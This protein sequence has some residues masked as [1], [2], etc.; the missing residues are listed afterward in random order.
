MPQGQPFI[1][2]PSCHMWRLQCPTPSQSTILVM[3]FPPTWEASWDM[4]DAEPPEDLENKV[5]LREPH[6]SP[7]YV[8]QTIPETFP[9]SIPSLTLINCGSLLPAKKWPRRQQSSHPELREAWWCLAALLPKPSCCTSIP[10]CKQSLH[11]GRTASAQSL[12]PSPG[13][14]ST[15]HHRDEDQWTRVNRTKWGLNRGKPELI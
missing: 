1:Y 11:W 3:C 14:H 9:V 5:L 6:Q 2:T 15:F 12:L 7:F 4:S 8:V 13:V 10:P